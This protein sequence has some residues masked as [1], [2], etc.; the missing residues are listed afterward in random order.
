MIYIS[1]YSA[2]QASQWD[3][4]VRSSRNGTFL[5]LRGYMDYHSDRFR[6]NSLV[7]RNEKGNIV[8]VMPCN[9]IGDELHSHQ[10]LT[11]GGFILAPSTHAYEV[12]E[13]FDVTKDYLRQQC[14]KKWFYKPVPTIYHDIPTQ[15]EEYFLWKNGARLIECNLSSTIDYRAQQPLRIDS[16][17]RYIANK[18][19]KENVRVDTNTPL[20][21][22]WSVLCRNLENKYGA[23]PVHSLE[24]ITL[25]QSR[26]PENIRCCT[27]V[28]PTNEILAGT[29]VYVFRQVAH[30]Q[31]SSASEQGQS[32][33][34]QD[35][36]YSALINYY[37]EMPQIH[38]FDLGTSNE[39]HGK[40][41]NKSLNTY[42][43]HF[44]ARGVAY[45]RYLIEL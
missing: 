8:A 18:L 19:K 23:K 22:F 32:I 6:D 1:P 24:E 44:G 14:F 36:L 16:S 20:Q 30:L 9:A 27:A 17:R 42:K 38:Y 26:F 3:S 37:K 2:E 10:G 39:E 28:S 4:F 11:Y 40:I 7:Y 15:E 43:E 41:L 45:K 29:V 5:F 34:A 33:G 31:Y 13:I 35:F 25:L 12:E 21:N